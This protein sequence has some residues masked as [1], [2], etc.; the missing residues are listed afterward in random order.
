MFE[1]R[2]IGSRA[3][4]IPKMYGLDY[5]LKTGICALLFC[6]MKKYEIQRR[7]GKVSG[8]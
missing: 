5:G 4:V 2:A 7:F 3:K 8:G 1:Y 6:I